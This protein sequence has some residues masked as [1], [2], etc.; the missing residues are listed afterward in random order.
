MPRT[1]LIVDDDPL[2]RMLLESVLR[3]AGYAVHSAGSIQEALRAV[4]R[5]PPDAAIVDVDLGEGPSG[6]NLLGLWRVQQQ[7]PVMVL[8]G[9]GEAAD[10][11]TGLE[12]G[13]LDYLAKPFDPRELL[14]RLKLVLD[15]FPAA[16]P[17]ATMPGSWRLGDLVFDA[18]RR[19]LTAGDQVIELTTLEFKLIDFLVQRA[20]QV[21]TREQ[22]LDAVHQRDRHVNDRAVDV[23]VGRMR[24]K[25]SSGQV[26]IQSIRGAGYML[27]GEVTRA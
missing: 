19:R 8:S 26:Q 7:F 27:C 1:V 23:L 14:L 20:N 10:R 12:Q 9:R 5:H 16:G 2:L 17:A 4:E 3:E 18:G 13:A 25:L 15:R 24:K 21:V 11:I 22:I 6:L